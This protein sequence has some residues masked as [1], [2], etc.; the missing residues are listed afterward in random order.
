M[1]NHLTPPLD[2]DALVCLLK[3][4][5]GQIVLFHQLDQTANLLHIEN[6]A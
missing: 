4:N 1:C 6:V 3:I 5:L 2:A